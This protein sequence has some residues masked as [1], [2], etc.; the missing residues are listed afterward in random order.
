V[1][2]DR[3]HSVRLQF[4]A[5]PSSQKHTTAEI[6]LYLKAVR[7]NNGSKTSFFLSGFLM[8]LQYL[9]AL[10]G[11]ACVRFVPKVPRATHSL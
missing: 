9:P 7:G 5:S 1:P 3:W 11:E 2:S 4:I 8:F 10:Q 6:I